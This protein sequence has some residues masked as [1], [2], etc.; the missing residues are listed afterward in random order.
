MMAHTS[1]SASAFATPGDLKEYE[2]MQ[3]F[4]SD[5]A[6]TGAG[7]WA[8][9]VKKAS[10]KNTAK[11]ANGNGGAPTRKANMNRLE[12][13]DPRIAEWSIKLGLLLK[14]ELSPNPHEGLPWYI[15]F[16][17][18]YWLYEK[19]KHFFVSG[20]PIKGKLFKTPQEFGLHLLWL[21]SSSQDRR[22]CCCV[23]CNVPP[24]NDDD[25]DAQKEAP[26]AAPAASPATQ[27]SSSTAPTAAAAPDAASTKISTIKSRK[28]VRQPAS[29]TVTAPVYQPV[30][31][32]SIPALFRTGELV[33]YSH[34]HSWR[35]GLVTLSEATWHQI[36]PIGHSSVLLPKIS[37][38][39]VDIRPFL[40]FSVP[41]VSQE[42]LRGLS[43]D[44]IPWAD[45]VRPLQ[46][47][48]NTSAVE[49]LFLDASKL[50]ALKINRSYSFFN[51]FAA[52]NGTTSYKGMFL[53]A[54][55]IHVEDVLRINQTPAANQMMPQQQQQQQPDPMDTV[56][57]YLKG[58]YTMDA[59]PGTIFFHGDVVQLVNQPAAGANILAPEQL[60]RALFEEATFRN[61]SST[62]AAWKWHWTVVEGNSWRKE[63]DVKGRFYSMLQLGPILMP[64]QMK[65]M[66]RDK[67]MPAL[68]G[69]LE[70]VLEGRNMGETKTRMETVRDTV[71]GNT[72]FKFDEKEVQYE[73]DV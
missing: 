68:N 33:W 27:A 12:P 1:A 32:T 8:E 15:P 2:M 31:A 43:F 24:K 59:S 57:F 55:R 26:K 73:N 11:D 42:A 54:E 19:S 16:P 72:H 69:R 28:P 30:P 47:S 6:D 65:T 46:A 37:K 62:A 34:E 38:A 70:A 45:R 44:Q 29:A 4:R 60:P 64:A 48:G 58:I 20:Y 61:N 35:L 66:P 23:F 17:N 25:E 41:Q 53:G 18:G 63:P 40:A 7:Y 5:G 36:T 9:P 21:L 10:A 14:Q 67:L 71:P 13:D 22:D 3:I 39:P 56:Y 50:G 51:R 52:N 49:S